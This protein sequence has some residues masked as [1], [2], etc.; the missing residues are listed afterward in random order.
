MAG[1]LV[2]P[3][4][5]TENPPV[6]IFMGGAD[7][8]AEEIYFIACAIVDGPGRGG[9][10]RLK[11]VQA[12]PDYEKP[13]GAIIDYLETRD[14]VDPTRVALLGVSMGGYAVARAARP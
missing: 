3:V 12:I 2:H 4:E 1:Y 10:L 6:L 11:K 8:T 5:P 7:S 14:D 13:T 9:M